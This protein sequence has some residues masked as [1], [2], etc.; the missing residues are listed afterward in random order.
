V[1]DIDIQSAQ[2]VESDDQDDLDDES[3]LDTTKQ[4]GFRVRLPFA[5]LALGVAVALGIWGG[6]KLEAGQNTPIAATAAGALGGAAGRGGAGAANTAGGAGRGGISGT[7]AS[8]QGSQIQLVTSTG[9]TVTVNLLPST[10]IART[11]S[12]PASDLSTGE[13]VT[14]RGQ[15]GAD[16]NTT[17]QAVTV[18][19]A[20]G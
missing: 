2:A 16:G 1:T 4:K 15:T 10:A 7:I 5:A 6:A 19:P 11:A 13:T 9:S 3:W 17:A 8:V 20:G 12:A 18:V 14:V